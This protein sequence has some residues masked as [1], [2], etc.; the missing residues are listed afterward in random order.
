MSESWFAAWVIA[1]VVALIATPLLVPRGAPRR[2]GRASLATA[3]GP[4]LAVGAALPFV[5]PELD[6][7]LGVVL[8]GAIGLWCAGQMLEREALPPIAHPLAMGLAASAAVVAGLRVDLTG[9]EWLDA[10]L[11]VAVIWGATSAWRSA[12]TR[13][14]LLL[15]WTAVIAAGAA[16]LGGLGT[17]GG[18]AVLG[19]AVVGAAFGFLPYV[20]PPVVARLRRGGSLFLGFLTVTLAVAARPSAPGLSATATQLLLVAIPLIEGALGAAARLRG[21]GT[22]PRLLGLVGRWR[23]QGLPRLAVTLGL[24][25]VQAGLVV[26]ALFVGRGVVDV[27]TGAVLGALVLGLVVIPAFVVRLDAPPGRWPRWAFVS[28]LVVIGALVVFAVPAAL[29]LLRARTDTAEGATAANRALAAARRGDPEAAGRAFRE[30][31]DRFAAA[32]GR[33]DGVEVQLG[34]VV[35]VLGPNLDAAK[36]L[37]DVGVDLAQVGRQLTATAD[38]DQLRIVNSTV[39]LDQLARLRP[40]FERTATLLTSAQQ[41]IDGIDRTFLIGPI[42]DAVLKLDRRIARAARDSRTA[43]IS[44]RILPSI[45]GQGVNRRYLLA[46]QNNA[47]A[48][49]T[50]GF[51][52][53]YAE[54]TAVEGKVDMGDVEPIRNL[55]PTSGETRTLE[56]PEEYLLRYGRFHPERLWQNVNTSPDVPTVGAVEAS[57]VAQAPFGPVDGVVT[58]DPQ[59]LAAILRITG[60]ITVPGWPEPVT[61][62]NVV[63]T[64]LRDA[65]IYFEGDN[66]RR[67]DFLGDVAD[68]AWDAFSNRDLGSPG[69]VVKELARATRA[70]H[71]TL[72]FADPEAQRLARRAGADGAVPRKTSD[73]VLVTTGN[74]AQNKIDFFLKRK[75][76]YDVTLFPRDDTDEVGARATLT[77]KLRNTAPATGLPSYIIGSNRPDYA[78]GENGTFFSAYSPLDLETATIDGTNTGMEQQPELG[79]QVYSKFLRIPAESTTT[80]DL[81]LAGQLRLGPDGWYE[82]VLGTQPA[83]NPDQARVGLRLPDGWRFA[84]ARGGVRIDDSGRRATFNGVIDRDRRLRLRIT[85]DHGDSIWG[86]LQDGKPL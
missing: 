33:L 44:S 75:L 34:G 59:G 80:V 54:L 76:R 29:A 50:G 48:R 68:A 10:V 82:L 83:V 4:L 25:A 13:D 67:E 6:V 1:T 27:T 73:L 40:E 18:V 47:E 19:A 12:Q 26:I 22:D 8:L 66:Q 51:I 39:N 35:P 81:D 30:A 36:D 28:A 2:R 84:E 7:E 24:V 78:A 37:V 45:L 49:A 16:L 17:A 5:I 52:G 11:T 63:D 64:T 42:E 86:H 38:P 3:A 61:A 62:E 46:M 57:L 55:N 31:E 53:N 20:V 14:G 9:V 79:R 72:W 77:T 70:K 43:A 69:S 60:P 41:R 85:R 65:Y 74:A 21:R 58:I 56:A 23:A 15:G 71:L 32:Q